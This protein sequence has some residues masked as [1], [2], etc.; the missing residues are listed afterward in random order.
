MRAPRV[1]MRGRADEAMPVCIVEEAERSRRAR[2]AATRRDDETCW[3][4][5]KRGIGTKYVC[6]S[7]NCRLV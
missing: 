2:A 4:V 7:D 3:S 5:G 1:R 6:L